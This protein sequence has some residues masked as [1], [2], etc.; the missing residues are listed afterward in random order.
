MTDTTRREVLGWL[1]GLGAAAG[2]GLLAP[3]RAGASVSVTALRGVT[4]IDSAGTRPN[5]TIVLA[6]NKILAVG[7]CDL[8]LPR[9][10]TVLDLAGKFVIPGAL[11]VHVHLELPF[12]GTVS[13]DDWNCGT[14][15]AARV[16]SLPTGTRRTCQAR[17]SW[18]ARTCRT[19]GRSSGR[20][21]SC[22]RTNAVRRYS[23]R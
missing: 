16:L 4:I 15:A 1:A 11:D 19:S 23:D 10:S 3:G 5:A 21:T 8:P 14:R 7:S 22:R 9:G 2:V 12:C 18:A 17:R 6:D 20:G 13:S